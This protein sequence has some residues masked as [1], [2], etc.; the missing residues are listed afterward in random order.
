MKVLA[1]IPA[2]S[3]VDHR[4]RDALDRAGV[5]FH[6]F[7]EC[8]DLPKARSQLL[9]LGLE[10]SDADAFLLLDSDMTPTAEQIHALA[11]HPSFGPLDAVV[12]AYPTREGM[13]AAAPLVPS[14]RV[15]LGEA[16]PLALAGAGL[17]F[18]IVHRKSL[19]RIAKGPRLP[20]VTEVTVG[21]R[22]L[23]FCL[24]LVEGGTYYPDDYSLWWRLRRVG[25]RVWLAPELLIGHLIREP[26]APVAGT[27]V[28][29]EPA[30]APTP[31][32]TPPGRTAGKPARRKP[33]RAKRH[34]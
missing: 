25:G 6:P 5:P 3:H 31:A 2:Y 11:N 16:G 34:R 27:V 14:A 15:T 26:R 22:W 23:P 33:T 17:G 18:A 24:P 9:T 20:V 30:P 1:L 4:L 13:L 7:H 28:G 12:G 19:E 8:S 29:P 32:P 21:A 10:Q